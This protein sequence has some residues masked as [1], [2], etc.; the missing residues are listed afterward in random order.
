M[1]KKIL[2]RLEALERQRIANQEAAE[3]ECFFNLARVVVPAYFLGHP[4]PKEWIF[5][6]FGRA[7]GFQG[8]EDFNQAFVQV[9]RDKNISDCRKRADEAFRR[10]FSEFGYDGSSPEAFQQGIRRMTDQLPERWKAWIMKEVNKV[11]YEEEIRREQKVEQV[12]R[13]VEKMAAVE[14]ATRL[15]KGEFA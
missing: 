2:K 13:T 14:A 11:N 9:F 12:Y 7:L 1:K 15:R 4:K 6:A 8:F 3:R 10:L 5:E